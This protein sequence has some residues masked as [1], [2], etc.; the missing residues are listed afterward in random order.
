[1]VPPRGWGEQGGPFAASEMLACRNGL[2]HVPSY[3]AGREPCFVPPTPGFFCLNVLHYDFQAAAPSPC[4]GC[5]SWASR[6]DD[7]ASIQTLQEWCGYVLTP[8]TRQQKILLLLGPPRSGKGTILRVLSELVGPDNVV[9][10]TLSSLAM[11]SGMSQLLDKTL[12]TIA[13]ASH[14]GRSGRRPGRRKAAVNL[15]RGPAQTIDRKNLAALTC[16]LGVRFTIVSNEVPRLSDNSGALCRGWRR[17]GWTCSFR[18]REDRRLTRGCRRSARHP[19][20]HWRA[21]PWST[22]AGTFAAGGGRHAAEM[23]DVFGP[24]GAFVRDAASS[25]RTCG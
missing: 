8:D 22:S 14:S 20:R 6:G 11:G 3:V 15:G 1:M 5:T 10:P 25:A 16:K 18:G 19:L 12:A 2:L 13:D 17:C 4:S 24:I 21:G 7:A 9:S 23:H